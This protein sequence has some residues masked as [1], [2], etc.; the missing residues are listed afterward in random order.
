MDNEYKRVIA[1]LK[2]VKPNEQKVLNALK[3]FV[4]NEYPHSNI[5]IDETI[6]LNDPRAVRNTI[7]KIYFNNYAMHEG[8]DSFIFVN[9]SRNRYFSRYVI[10]GKD[11]ISNLIDQN[12]IKSGVITT[13]DLDPSLG[14][15]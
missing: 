13:F 15:I 7:T 9:T 6:T 10:F 5:Q 8:V 11:D 2:R 3:I 12:L 14:T 1:F 4:R